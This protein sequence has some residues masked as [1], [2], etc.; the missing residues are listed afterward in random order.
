MCCTQ[1]EE[2][3]HSS[4]AFQVRSIPAWPVQL[5]GVAASVNVI[6]GDPPQLSVAVAVPVF[7]GAVESPHCNC[8]SGGQVITGEVVSLTVI[9]WVQVVVLPAGSLAR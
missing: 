1:V 3:P 5:A 9:V 4:V 7:A 6:V 8:L 2:L